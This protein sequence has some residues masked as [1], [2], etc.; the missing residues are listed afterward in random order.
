MKTFGEVHVGERCSELCLWVQLRQKV[1][2]KKVFI[3]PLREHKQR[4][5]DSVTPQQQHSVIRYARTHTHKQTVT[6]PK[7]HLI[8]VLASK[9]PSTLCPLHLLV[10]TLQTP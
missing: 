6:S 5:S 1:R 9:N 10:Y 2:W 8:D 4:V 3:K 7:S